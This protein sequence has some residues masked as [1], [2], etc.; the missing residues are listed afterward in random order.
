VL[1][2][3]RDEAAGEQVFAFPE[4]VVAFEDAELL[5]V[6]WADGD[7]DASAVA[8]LVS[9]WL[10]HVRAGG[11]DEDAVVGRGG[12]PALGAVGD[13]DFDLVV[14]AGVLNALLGRHGQARVA[15]DAPDPRPDLGQHAGLIAAAAAD[16]QHF[17][18]RLDLR[19]LGHGRDH[20]GLA[21]GLAAGGGQGPVAV[22][23]LRRE[24]GDKLVPGDHAHGREH[25]G[26]VDAAGLELA[27]DHAVGELL[28]WKTF[29]HVIPRAAH[30]SYRDPSHAR[31]IF[32]E[33]LRIF[34]L[35]TPRPVFQTCLVHRE[36]NHMT[37]IDG[38]I[39]A[40][41]PATDAPA[42]PD[43]GKS[44]PREDRP[45]KTAVADHEAAPHPADP[46]QDGKATA[47]ARPVAATAESTDDKAGRNATLSQ[48]QILDVTERCL[49]SVGYDKTTIRKIAGELDCA[50]GS[51]YR[52]F[53]DKRELLYAVC[54]RRMERTARLIASGAELGECVLDYHHRVAEDPGSYRM[55][56]WLAA[57]T[58]QAQAPDA[59]PT[60]PPV[61]REIID[62]WALRLGSRDAA[63]RLWASVHGSMMIGHD[64]ARTVEAAQAALSRG[65]QAPAAA[66]DTPPADAPPTR[67]DVT[68]L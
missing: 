41:H 47:T 25:V 54:Q 66:R 11:G 17:H 13:E 53:K 4:G 3:E 7:D 37:T 31:D 34:A 29:T 67:D 2:Q 6:A 33:S 20:V 27:A 60:V 51:I 43:R 55:M 61:I 16:F 64:A 22:G 32:S 10:G 24:V 15:F 48:G 30:S 50:V 58:Q 38:A 42:P 1:A 35:D 56:F 23:L 57:V 49:R 46:S 14:E 59:K 21:D 28:M 65:G 8:G 39:H 9:E 26:I 68:L 12:G 19:R 36:V 52:Y 40:Q 45:A 5:V 62:A 63:D 18:A 44:T